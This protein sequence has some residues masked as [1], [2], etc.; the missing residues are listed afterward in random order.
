MY[1]SVR[2]KFV[3][4]LLGSTLWTLLSIWLSREWFLDLGTHIGILLATFL[5]AGI[6][7][8][9]GFMNSFLLCSL[10]DHV[11][12]ASRRAIPADHPGCRLQRRS[13]D[14]DTLRSI[15]EQAPMWRVAGRR[16]QRARRYPVLCEGW[17]YPG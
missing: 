5:I 8:V 7:I 13:F 3:L 10:S 9:P 17:Q 15:D 12:N 14:R 2:I 11:L 4:A 16:D 1:L 6:A